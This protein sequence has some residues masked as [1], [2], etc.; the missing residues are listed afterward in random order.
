M[1]KKAFAIRDSRSDK[2]LYTVSGGMILLFTLMVLYPLVFIVSCSFSSGI[3]VSTGRVV[4]W[5][6]KPT[7]DGYRAVFTYHR[8]RTGYM[9]TMFY[10]IAGTSINVFMTLITAY[11]LAMPRFQFKRIYL[12]LFTFTMFFSG[13]MVPYY[14]LI[15]NLGLMNTRWVMLIPGAMSVYNMIV[16]R[17]FIQN[18]IP[19]E[20]LEASQIDGCSWFSYFFRIVL[21]LSKAVIAVITLYYAV[22]HWNAYFDA[23]IFINDRD[24]QPLQLVLR[25]IL[26]NNSLEVTDIETEE[27]RKMMSD[28]LKYALIVVATVPILCVY[29]FIQ[30]YFMKGVMIG[31]VK[32]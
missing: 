3:A 15:S 5:P 17:T 21:P 23:M 8:I 11:P 24:L 19:T 25:E 7:I 32:G 9:N 12:L 13:G 18:S 30:K 10:T 31:S 20:L 2:V 1:E 14:I 16:T 4:F 22:G 29:P 27:A 28:L 6:V 26:I